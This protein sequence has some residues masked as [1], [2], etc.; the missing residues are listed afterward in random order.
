MC[1]GSH[2]HAVTQLFGVHL[3]VN[4][5]FRFGVNTLYKT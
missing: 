5:L 3:H 4:S 2:S 1:N